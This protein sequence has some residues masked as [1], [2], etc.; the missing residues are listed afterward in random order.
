MRLEDRARRASDDIR[1]AVGRPDTLERFERFRERKHRRQR[2]GA[3]VLALC[4]AALSILVATRAFRPNPAPTPAAP[5]GGS[6]LYGQW[7]AKLEKSQWFT[8]RPD[9]SGV[10]NLHTLVTC[11]VWWPDGSRI[12]ITDDAAEG[13]G[14]PLRPAT[15]APDGSGLRALDAAKAPN[16]NLGCGDVSP[17]GSR[18]VLE[19]FSDHPGPLNG[20]YSVRASDGGGLVRLTRGRDGVPSFSP[21][22]TQVAFFRQRDGVSPPGAGALFVVNADGTDLHRITPWGFAFLGQSWSPDGRWIAFQRPYGQ[23]YLVHPDG[24]GLHRLPLELPAGAGAL[25]P[26]WSPDGSRIAFSLSRNGDADI[27]TVR[28]DGTRLTRVTSSTGVNLQTPDWG[29]TQRS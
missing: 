21:D 29:N 10:R 20:I 8:V 18:L 15:I 28:A 16:L 27:Y 3:G 5:S 17:E 23:L 25:N 6:I 2:I 22:G 11:A 9:G 7:N 4:L 24:T 26:A 1:R 13:P 19:G 12:L 14:Q